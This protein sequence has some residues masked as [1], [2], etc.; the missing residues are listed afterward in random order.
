METALEVAAASPARWRL[1]AWIAGL[2][3]T[4]L[5][6]DQLSVRRLLQRSPKRLALDPAPAKAEPQLCALEWRQRS[7]GRRVCSF[8]RPSV[9]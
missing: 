5:L 9:R 1:G 6:R 3:L 8:R 7:C 4:A 2:E